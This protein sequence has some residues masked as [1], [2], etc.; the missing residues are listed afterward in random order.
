MVGESFGSPFFVPGGHTHSRQ[1]KGRN[2]K[3]LGFRAAS[4]VYL[5]P[6]QRLGC[7]CTR[8]TEPWKGDI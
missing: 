2:I 1:A 3:Y 7:E 6:R 5:S 8:P 4:P